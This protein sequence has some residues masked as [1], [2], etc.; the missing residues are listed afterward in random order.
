V[1][2]VPSAVSASA[3]PNPI[4]SGSNLTLT[5]TAT[6]STGSVTYAWSGPNGFTSTAQNPAAFAVTTADAGIYTVTATNSCGNTTATTAT[7]TVNVV[8]SAVSASATPNP[9]CSGSNLTLTSTATSSTGS[10]TYAWSGPNG[11]TSTN[12]NPAAFAVT[13]ADAGIYTVTATNAC[14]NTTAITATVTVNPA[15]PVI[16]A[17]ASPNPVCIGSNLV[18]TA[19][20]TDGDT[21]SWSGPNGFSSAVQNPATFSA[22]GAS[23]GVYT[24][25]VTNGCGSVSATTSAVTVNTTPVA[26]SANATPNPVCVDVNITL[27]SAAT[28]AVS[29]S[30]AGPNGFSSTDQN[31]VAFA[32]TSSAAG[33]YTV[34]ATNACGNTTAVTS[35]VTVNPLADPGVIVGTLEICQSFTSSLSNAVPGGIWSSGNLSVATVG[36]SGIVTGVA[37][38]VATISY[39]LSNVCGTMYATR[40]FTVNSMPA[41]TNGSMLL[42][43]GSTFS[44]LSTVSGGTWSSDNNAV[45]TIVPATGAVTATTV[46]TSTIEYVTGSGCLA[47]V[48]V[49]VT[50]ALTPNTGETYMCTGQ[51]LSGLLLSN[52]TPGGTWV[53][54]DMATVLINSA[55]GYMRGLQ[56]GTVTITYMLS[57][58]C[59]ST[60]VETVI[61]AV[62]TITNTANICPGTGVTLTNATGGGTWSSTNTTKA[63]IDVNTGLVTGIAAGTSTITYYI[64]PGCYKTATQIVNAL[65]GNVSGTAALCQGA[66]STLVCSPLG[67]TWV[68]ADPGVATVNSTTGVV[69]TGLPGITT[70]TYTATT[71]CTRTRDITINALPTAVT[72]TATVCIGSVT[73]LN[74]TPSGGVWTSS[75]AGRASVD[76]G[77][78]AVTGVT[79]GTVNLTYTLAGCTATKQVTVN[80]LPAVIAG[81]GTVCTGGSGMLTT[82]PAGGVWTSSTPGIASVNA[83]TGLVTAGMVAGNTTITYEN[84]LG[85][86]RTKDITVNTTPSAI[87]GST[88]VCIGSTIALSSSGGGTWSS[89][90]SV[91]ASVNAGTGVVTGL[92]E[93]TATI[94]YTVS[95]GCYAV[96]TISVN[97]VPVAISGS[98]IVCEGAVAPLSCTP[99]SGTWSSSNLSVTTV[100]TN[101]VVTGIASGFA[102]VTYHLPT[103]CI[104]VKQVTVNAIPGAIGGT[105][106]VCVGNTTTLNA[107]PGSGTWTSSNSTY[108]TVNAINGVVTGIAAGNLTV[109]Y[110]GTNGCYRTTQVTVNP[111]PSVIAGSNTVCEGAS[112]ALS[113]VSAGGTWSSSEVDVA[114][115]NTTTGVVTGIDADYG[116]GFTVISYVLPTGCARTTNVTVNSL[117]SA[118]GGVA[119]VCINNTT[120]LNATPGGG[121]WSSSNAARATV[122]ATTGVV[123]G[124]TAGTA[125]VT[126]SVNGCSNTTQ[127]TVMAAPSVITGTLMVCE[128]NA[129]TLAST[130]TGGVW[131]SG[132]PAVATINAVTGI[133]SGVAVGNAAIT[134]T[135]INGC[136]T[137]GEVTVNGAVTPNTGYPLLCT[138]Q[139]FSVTVLSNAT[140]GGTW[141]SAD[142][143]KVILSP[144]SGIMRGVSTGTTN[145]TYLLSAGCYSITEATV[146]AA[147]A[148]IT[149][150]ANVCPGSNVTLSNA[151]G[152]GTWSSSN[153]T[154]ATV[155]ALTGT[156]TGMASGTAIVTYMV[157]AACYKTTTQTVYSLPGTISGNT[158]VCQGSGTTL[159]C[160]PLGGTWSS[161]AP[162]TASVNAASGLVTAGSTPGVT[163]ITYVA[164]TGC[165]NSINVS[166]NPLPAAIS[167]TASMCVGANTTLNTTPGGGVWSSS[168]TGRVTVDAGTGVVLGIT[169]GTATVS[170]N[171]NG[172]ITVKQVT[173]NALPGAIAGASTVC[174]GTTATLTST[175]TGGVWSSSTPGVASINAS[176][177]LVTAGAGSGTTTI[178]YLLG[179]GCL[180]TRTLSVNSAPGAITGATGICI[181]SSAT[182]TSSGGGTWSSSNAVKATINAATGEVTGLTSGTTRISFIVGVGCY[183]TSVLSVNAQPAVI[184]GAAT[185][186]VGATLAQ[187][188][189]TTG[190]TWSS[191]NSLIATVGSA[192]GIVTGIDQGTITITYQLNT[193]CRQFKVLTVNESPSVIGGTA[194][195]CIGGTTSLNAT[196]GGGAW[197][198][199]VPSRATINAGTGVL[200]GLTAGTSVITYSLGSGCYKIRIATVN[201]LP[202]VITGTAT[203]C[204]GLTTTFASATAGGTWSSSNAAIATINTATRV[205]T[206]MGDG[207]ATITYQLATGCIRTQNVTVNAAP[208]AMSGTASVCIGST[209]T[210]NTTPGGGVWSSSIVAKA[211]VGSTGIVS[212]IAAGT[213]T[214][215]YLVNG[216]RTTKQVTVLSL[217]SVITGTMLVCAGNT[218]TVNATPTGGVWSSSDNGIASVNAGMLSGISD[219]NANISYTGTNGCVRS[220]TVTVNP[221]VTA[222]DGYALLC[223]GQPSSVTVLTNPTPGGVWSCDPMGRVVIHPSSGIMR[224]VT[225]GTTNITYTLSPGCYTVTQATVNGTVGATTGNANV[226]AGS[227]VTLLNGTGGGTWISSN[228]AIATIDPLSGELTGVAGGTITVTYFISNACYKTVAQTVLAA[229]AAISGASSVLTGAST[230]LSCSTAGGTWSS[231]SSAIATV[232]PSTGSVSGVAP[233]AATISYQLSNGC[234][235]TYNITVIAAKADIAGGENESAVPKT[236]TTVSFYPNPTSGVLTVKASSPGTFVIYSIEGRVI[237]QHNVI[238]ATTTIT[239]PND[240]AP[241]MY[242]CRYY[243]EDGAVIAMR[244]IYSK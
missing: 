54:S 11:F 230:T 64:N 196:P 223:T 226:C 200:S 109:S 229:P 22:I 2:V 53:S 138:D 32:A 49:T 178:Q 93:G 110:Q 15:V 103:G 7:V 194:A 131:T 236:A 10:V 145:I 25:V 179:T 153:V 111:L 234:R 92:T 208:D 167:G 209:T 224:G 61:P 73:T 37:G 228:G 85:C 86:I 125:D 120:T 238:E 28:N 95:A 227:Q 18:L 126:Y 8:P 182:L 181:G 163:T 43:A 58:G 148:A 35:V 116:S 45:V 21:Y 213:S 98:G 72:G 146:A 197:T 31:P 33:V 132:T 134:Y 201:A 206:G 19:S 207:I 135:G 17:D 198:S 108:A 60:T 162:A 121:I 173:V 46:G 237:D 159:A 127:V 63:T 176:T 170:Y 142:P 26:V 211:T 50:P 219:G 122:D 241:G 52:A 67:G 184:G 23:A 164:T 137:I 183:T 83:A 75:N 172:C 133:V 222:N 140:A 104:S 180:V 88:N 97:P 105:T 102:A 29:Y 128:G 6:S 171:L 13:T 27:T 119:S 1:N 40:D 243:A 115:I 123:A 24:L 65:P 141:S 94:S 38:G 143:S 199:S 96:T 117:P 68:S 20:V 187:S 91:K 177:G 55:S 149:S 214:I 221:T 165:S 80:S 210:L 139:P 192:N 157:S 41:I 242:M 239:L 74:T 155:D 78:G 84:T 231:P 34:T 66:T 69:T 129:A 244:L 114:T 216:C 154:V 48:V 71:G 30:W 44:F 202:A 220:A 82:T 107:T 118:I 87:T 106:A 218:V 188:N 81:A 57:A 189:T 174:S 190:G 233:G 136:Q 147:V 168:N 160:S 89:S 99:A 4:C 169:S 90:N 39:A 16:L 151:T 186:C 212:G 130:P 144:S 150:T 215:T 161:S 100:G 124:I 113:S 101:G 3:T 76:A 14:G 240:I 225:T 59:Y 175:P 112:L 204:E 56:T 12:Q 203:V 152:S 47:S 191:S 62:A 185:V 193:G 166:V 70:V 79:A 205:I 42:C 5:S 36:T 235:S 77:T 158:I 51:P 232:V 217:P 9:I 195:A 156:V